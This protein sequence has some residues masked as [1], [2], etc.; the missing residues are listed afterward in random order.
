MLVHK[1]VARIP[2]YRAV[3][4]NLLARTLALTKYI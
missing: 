4:D 1:V 3:H 2:P